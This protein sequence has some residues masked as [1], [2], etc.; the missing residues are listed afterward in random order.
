MKAPHERLP[1]KTRSGPEPVR[2]AHDTDTSHP[3]SYCHGRADVVPA[4]T[5]LLTPTSIK[6]LTEEQPKTNPSNA[7]IVRR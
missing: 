7:P 2:Q 6:G 1:P 3:E 4:P 5:S